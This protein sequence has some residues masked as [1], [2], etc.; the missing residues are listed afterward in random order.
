MAE[1]LN[2][3][4]FDYHLPDDKIAKYPADKRD[5]SKLLVYKKGII[6]DDHFKNIISYIPDDHLLV[7]N[8]TRVIQAR[9]L[10]KKTT[11]AE[12][13]IFCLEPVSPS[14][15][16]DIFNQKKTCIW[17]C[18]IGNLKK[19]K[20]NEL[21]TNVKF[22]G[23]DLVLTAKKLNIEHHYADIEF[24]WSDDR[25]SFGEILEQEGLTPIPP[26]L[27]RNS[28][29]ID[30][31]RYQ[32]I[33]SK[34]NGSV[35]APTA[36]LHFTEEVMQTLKN[37]NIAMT[38]ITLHVGAGTFRPVSS[39]DISDHEMHTE[40]Y[41]VSMETLELLNKYREKIIPVGTT[42]LRALESIYLTGLKI[43]NHNDDLK[44]GQWD[45]KYIKEDM[46][47]G[48]SIIAIINFLKDNQTKV[49]HNSTQIMITPGYTFRMARGLI[50]NFHQPKST[51]LLL[52]AAMIGDDWKKVYD[53]ALRN[54]FRFL[55][56]GDSSI[57]FS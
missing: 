47:S 11:G 27:N 41:S 55:S 44:T 50:T 37:R 43:Q 10:F 20:D 51:L 5:Q 6:S 25:F 30:R 16:Q 18:M 46:D 53:Y 48:T 34:S 21:K 38:E 52:V 57:I 14:S 9:L 24:S 26:Y 17:R 2:I 32:T 49:L 33:Y 1:N 42:S 4:D 28:E 15:Y 31:S 35:A 8:N 13:E 54:N 23:S 22:N 56:Y 3:S 39:A 40:H 19:W 7:F 12:I 36:G 45:Y 29:E